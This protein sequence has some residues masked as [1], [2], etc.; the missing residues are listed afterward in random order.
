M[1]FSSIYIGKS[2]VEPNDIESTTNY[3]CKIAKQEKSFNNFLEFY[4]KNVYMTFIKFDDMDTICY[5]NFNKD[6]TEKFIAITLKEGS[7]SA[8]IHSNNLDP[9]MKKNSKSIAMKYVL[10][11]GSDKNIINLIDNISSWN[12][13][14]HKICNAELSTDVYLYTHFNHCDERNHR[15]ISNRTSRTRTKN[16]IED[17]VNVDDTEVYFIFPIEVESQVNKF[18]NFNFIFFLLI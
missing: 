13:Y 11:I 7:Y 2:A 9:K 14:Q 1:K 6:G 15:N 16:L 17:K 12:L 4:Y 3:S 10:L 8:G 5:N 18:L